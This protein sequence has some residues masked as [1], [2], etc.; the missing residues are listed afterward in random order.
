[1]AC[2]NQMSS[3]EKEGTSDSIY[4]ISPPFGLQKKDAWTKTKQDSPPV[5][6]ASMKTKK[7]THTGLSSGT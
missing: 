2:T 4:I 5:N 1:M 7:K 6:A 3:L